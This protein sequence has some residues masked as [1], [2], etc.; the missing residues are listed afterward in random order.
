MD[1]E[2]KKLFVAVKA[3]VIKDQ[4][5]LVL[6]EARDKD[7]GT[8]PGKFDFPGGKMELGEKP[9]EALN[10]EV[11]EETG[12]KV[13]IGNP[14]A[15]NQWIPVVGGEKW[16]I[17]GIYF[18]CK[19]KDE[20]GIKLSHEHDSFKWIDPKKFKEHNLMKEPR[21]ILKKYVSSSKKAKIK[22]ERR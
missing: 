11:L 10:R 13:E 3:L 9:E 7:S 18:K 5:V 1:K 20:N 6:S 14:V 15:V 12:L 16:Q 8:N 2:I 4:K 21:E 19:L 22:F 17:V